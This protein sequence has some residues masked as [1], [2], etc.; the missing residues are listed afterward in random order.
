[1][2]APFCGVVVDCPDPLALAM[3]YSRLTGMAIDETSDG[4]DEGSWAQLQSGEHPTIGF[5]KVDAVTPVTWPTG[6]RPQR[7]HLDFA[8]DDLDE[9][10]AFALSLGARKANDQPGTTFRVFVDPIGHPFCLVRNASEVAASP[11]GA[12]G[13]T[14][15]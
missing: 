7:L 1:V 15:D 13:Q 12:Q 8:V 10:E 2:I 5:Q 6:E 14:I 9:G 3:F 11:G 4:E